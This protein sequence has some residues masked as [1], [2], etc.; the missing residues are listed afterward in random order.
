MKLTILGSGTAAPTL[1]R[2]TSGYLIEAGNQKLLFDSGPGT[3]IQLLKCG[4][5]IMSIDHIFYTHTHNDHINDLPALLWSYNYGKFRR[6]TLCLYGPKNFTRY[7]KLLLKLLGKK[8]FKFKVKIKEMPNNNTVKIAL[9]K[10]IGKQNQN[11]TIK[12]IKSNH[13]K[14]SVSYLIEQNGKS[15]VYSGD[16]GYS[17]EIIEISRNVDI[18]LLECSFP[19]DKKVDGHLTPKYCG[20]IAQ[21]SGAKSLILTHL[22][23]PCDS[24]DI[25]KQC[26]NEFNGKIQ[27]A[28]D[29]MCLQI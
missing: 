23:P 3:I 16:T 13:T 9:H 6:K 5:D 11:V 29:L 24:T 7:Y 22:Y 1:N 25:L 20:I 17:P 18:L 27:I 26:R 12:S 28:K 10:K 8:K 15:I 19:D 4:F 21:K 2:N 14:A